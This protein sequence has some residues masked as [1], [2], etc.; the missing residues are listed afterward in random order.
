MP[1][2]LVPQPWNMPTERLPSMLAVS[3]VGSGV[4]GSM[5]RFQYTLLRSSRVEQLMPFTLLPV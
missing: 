2:A 3:V 4:A 5:N 1:L